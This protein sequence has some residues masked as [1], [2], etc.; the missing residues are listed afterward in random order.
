MI[1][2]VT[3]R[4]ILN[5]SVDFKGSSLHFHSNFLPLLIPISP[6]RYGAPGHEVCIP[7]ACSFLTDYCIPCPLS[8]WRLNLQ[9]GCPQRMDQLAWARSLGAISE[10][11]MGKLFHPPLA[12]LSLRLFYGKYFIR[13]DT[14]FVDLSKLIL[15]R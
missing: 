3:Q 12:R 8:L 14:L 10:S 2:Q 4:D 7:P 9:Y 1:I 11:S 5:Y 15:T 13:C 6:F